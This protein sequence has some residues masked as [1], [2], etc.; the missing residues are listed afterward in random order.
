M[1]TLLDVARRA[2]V[3]SAT[4]SRVLNGAGRISESTR[5]RVIEVANHLG[6]QPNQ[7]AKSLRLGR[8]RSV[9]LLIGDI[10][11]GTYMALTKRVQLALQALD[12]DLLLF[13][14]DHREDRLF[15]FLDR[16]PT[17]GLLGVVMAVP[18][19]M[20]GRR[21]ARYA[22]RLRTQGMLLVAVGQRLNRL[23]VP[24]I[25]HDEVTG[26]GLAIDRLVTGGHWPLAYLGRTVT[27]ATGGARYRG[28]RAALTARGADT[29]TCELWE[30][31]D[32]FRAEAGYHVVGE[33]LRRGTHVRGVVAMSDEM[34]LGGIAAALD[35]GLAVPRDIAFVGYGAL[36]WGGY[37]RPAL[38]SVLVNADAV[39]EALEA[40]F[41]AHQEAREPRM[42]TIVRP[43]LVART[44]A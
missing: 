4:V 19:R 40:L 27:S 5:R 7:V 9:A 32:K 13:N 10:E 16:A 2:R 20:D 37:A 42:L 31:T 39:A 24:S 21:L 44:S 8:G 17:M 28:F 15:G 23:G 36:D 25:V 41:R 18:R 29:A 30:C 26:A 1:V 11:Q 6:Y 35:Q 3:S 38:T 34:A 14:L 22:E 12:L 43:A 33:A